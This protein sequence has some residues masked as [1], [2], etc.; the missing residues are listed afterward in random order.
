MLRLYT[1]KIIAKLKFCF[2]EEKL[3]FNPFV[4]FVFGFFLIQIQISISVEGF[5]FHDSRFRGLCA[6]EPQSG[7]R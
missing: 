5:T 7:E 4:F 1:S 6:P 2:L 3:H